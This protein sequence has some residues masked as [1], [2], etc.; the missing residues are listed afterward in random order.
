HTTLDLI[1]YQQ[2]IMAVRQLARLAGVLGGDGEDSAFAL[3]PFDDNAGGPIGYGVLE[4]AD[5][6]LRQEFY[7]FQQRLEIL[8]ILRLPGDRQCAQ[9]SPVERIL[10]RK[11]LDLFRVNLAAMRPHHLE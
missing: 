4:S 2:R 5:I 10:H 11:D 6:A 1:E 7:A 8:A 9:S 3:D